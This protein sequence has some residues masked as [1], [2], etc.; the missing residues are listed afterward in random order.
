MGAK[1]SKYVRNG[2]LPEFVMPQASTEVLRFAQNDNGRKVLT[3]CRQSEWKVEVRLAAHL[4]QPTL[5]F[6]SVS[7]RAAG[8]IVAFLDFVLLAT[9]ASTRSVCRV[10]RDPRPV[11]MTAHR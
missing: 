9:L 8:S 7:F 3:A 2:A 6:F 5:Y 1:R 4:P 11:E 10:W